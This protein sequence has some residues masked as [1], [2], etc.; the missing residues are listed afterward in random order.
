VPGALND[1]SIVVEDAK[2]FRDASSGT[3][4]VYADGLAK[5]GDKL[6]RKTAARYRAL[7]ANAVG[8]K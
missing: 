5:R 2:R 8:G 4:V 1:V 7:T 6:S 3:G